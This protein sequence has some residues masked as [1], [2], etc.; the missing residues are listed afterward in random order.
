M[1]CFDLQASYMTKYSKLIQI[2]DLGGYKW[3]NNFVV[4][5]GSLAHGKHIL[6]HAPGSTVHDKHIPPSVLTVANGC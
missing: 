1:R 4:R 5:Q 2:W 3:K 6:C